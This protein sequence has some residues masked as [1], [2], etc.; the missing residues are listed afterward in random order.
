MAGGLA[1]AATL[2]APSVFGQDGEWTRF[3][4]SNG[5][6]IVKD[7]GVPVVFGEKEIA[8]STVLPG[9]GHSSPVAWG[10][11]VFLTCEAPDGSEMR[12]I[13]AL[14]LADGSIL[15]KADFPFLP[16]SLHQFNNM[17]S[18]TPCVDAER[19]YVSWETGERREVIAMSHD[20]REMWRRDLGFY[21]ENHGTAASPVLVEG[22]LVV[23]NDH[24]GEGGAILGLDPATGE[25]LWKHVRAPEKTSFTTPVV[26][27]SE[28]GRATVIVAGTPYGLT[29][30][31]PKDGSVVWK[32]AE[33]FDQRTVGSPVVLGDLVFATSGQGGGGKKA[34]AVKVAPAKE[35]LE[36][37]YV[38]TT[39]LP[40][41]PTPV[42][43]DGLIFLWT[44]AGVVNCLDAETGESIWRERASGPCFASPI[45]VGDVLLGVDKQGAVVA[46]RAG[47][48]FEVV[49]RSEVGEPV[50]ATPAV[51]GDRLLIRTKSKLICVGGKAGD[52]PRT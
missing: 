5:S 38:V 3:R 30:L 2:A 7:E 48:A 4:G 34:F 19:V 20:G 42:A 37:E 6:G 44:D 18:T 25:E 29:A 17:A 51:V 1:C 13:V 15:W 27:R 26:H 47:R 46:L 14:A 11:R 9:P 23:P 24:E 49:G 32:A 36:S 43:R 45:C 52:K 35:V 41:V 50:D 8:W 21:A 39:G 33:S 31:D 12:S 40:Y 16:H 10:D 28:S 22:V